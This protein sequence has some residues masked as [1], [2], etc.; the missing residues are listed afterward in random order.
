MLLKQYVPSQW[1]CDVAIDNM[2]SCNQQLESLTYY[3]GKS[4]LFTQDS[5]GMRPWI[6]ETS[7]DN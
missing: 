3:P 7:Q 1:I 6:F 5:G 2:Q 4:G